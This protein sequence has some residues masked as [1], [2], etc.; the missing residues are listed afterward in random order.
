[1]RYIV[2]AVITSVAVVYIMRLLSHYGFSDLSS[3]VSDGRL[4]HPAPPVALV[5]HYYAPNRGKPRFTRGGQYYGFYTTIW[6][7]C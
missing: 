2:G 6:F 5:G 7:G 3:I 1:V 4:K